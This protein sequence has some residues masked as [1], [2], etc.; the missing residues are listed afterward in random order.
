MDN[1]RRPVASRGPKPADT[2]W[3]RPPLTLRPVGSSLK[4]HRALPPRRPGI[5]VPA[6][7]CRVRHKK[8]LI[9]P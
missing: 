1:T 5:P 9:C 3:L 2:R 4:L 8:I 7:I 6:G